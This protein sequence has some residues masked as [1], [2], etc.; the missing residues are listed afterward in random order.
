MKNFYKESFDRFVREVAVQAEKINTEQRK[1]QLYDQ[2]TVR[3]TRSKSKK[4]LHLMKRSPLRNGYEAVAHR[5]QADMPHTD[6][7]G[8]KPKPTHVGKTKYRRL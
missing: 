3:E 6:T 8:K 4:V 2:N 7:H 1:T 5:H